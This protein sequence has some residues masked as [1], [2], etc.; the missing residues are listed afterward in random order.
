MKNAI[1]ITGAAARLAQEVA[2]IDLLL[3]KGLEINQNDT[4]VA[5]FSSG[6]INALAINTC[7]RDNSP[8][9]WNSWYKEEKL[10]KMKDSDVFEFLPPTFKSI[11]NTAPFQKYMTQVM[12]EASVHDFGSL[13]FKS[14]VVTSQYHDKSTYWADNQI[15]GHAQ[16]SPVDLFMSSTAI[17]V[18]LPSHGIGNTDPAIGNNRDFPSGEFIDGG[19]WGTFI[20]YDDKLP[21]FVKEHG[22]F[23]ELHVISP[24]RETTDALNE[25]KR[26]YF[27]QW[28][29]MRHEI[30]EDDMDKFMMTFNIG[31]DAF[32]TF[33][34]GLNELNQSQS[35]A[36]NI[37]VSM[38]AMPKNTGMLSFGK[39]K[40][41]YDITMQWMRSADGKGQVRVPIENF[42]KESH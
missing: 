38:P 15:P 4:M 27:R 9:D 22:V 39:Q 12:N 28:K 24:M 1:M 16:L 37:Y 35:I 23:E 36:K 11:L 2:M 18:V 19:S 14:F 41:A 6:S 17:P 7:F 25:H 34:K 33:L 26:H 13:P 31:L 3:E 20:H 21:A 8:K 30:K 5:G 40:E 32:I 29:E 10:W 42:L